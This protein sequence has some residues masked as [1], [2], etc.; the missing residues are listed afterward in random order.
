ML[1]HL[2]I[3]NLTVVKQ[4]AISVQRGLTAITGETGAGK[5]IALDALGLCLGSRADS[6]IVRQG[7]EKSEIV[8]HFDIASLAHAQQWL[9]EHELSQDDSND[10]CFIRRVVSSEGRSKAFINGI[11]VNLNQL[12]SFGKM[13][14]NIHGQHDHHALFKHDTQMQML[15]AYARQ[16]ALLEKL[17]SAYKQYKDLATTLEDLKN[18]QQQR[19]DR[20]NLLEYQVNELEEFAVTEDEFP[21][22]EAE[23]KRLNSLQSL[24][25]SSDKACYLLK[26]GEPASALDLLSHAAKEIQAQI[27]TDQQLEEAYEMMQNAIIQAQ[28]AYSELDRYRNNDQADPERVLHIENRYSQYLELARKHGTAPENLYLSFV[29]LSEEL[30]TLKKQEADLDTIQEDTKQALTHYWE[31][32]RKVSLARVSAAKRMSKEIEESIRQLNMRY[33][34]VDIDVT[35]SEDKAVSAVGN[36]TIDFKVSVNPGQTPDSLEK[37]VSGGELSRIGLVLQVIYSRNHQIPTLIFDEVDTGISGQ[38]ASVVGKL[39]RQLGE[40]SQVV[41]VTHL[42]QVAAQAH[43]QLFVNKITDG[44]T[45]ETTVLKL[46][47]ADRVNE[48]A[49]LLA[50]DALTD[51]AIKNARE[52]LKS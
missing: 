7:A 9:C 39:L 22:L 21:H 47:K 24:I 13:L 28:E 1:V 51:S 32:A 2:D 41:S 38:T 3:K 45:T 12:K 52:L 49:R 4:V 25:E 6:G 23:F 16:S 48:I 11:P 18:Q 15:D 33:A 34:V 35:F 19:S 27:D 14:V 46:T 20:V 30:H 8:A 36:D 26:D 43:N 50:G 17:K 10:E 40:Q 5:S 42:P 44:Q 31:I 29:A 37:V